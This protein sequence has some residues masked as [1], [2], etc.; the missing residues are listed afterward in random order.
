MPSR[1]ALLASAVLPFATPAFAQSWPARPFRFV[2]PF[3][4]GASLDVLARLIAA[5]FPEVTGQNAVTENRVGGG[6]IIG[7]DS[8]AKLPGDGYTVL[9]VA[10]SF[11]INATL[12][13]NPPFDARRD[14]RGIDSLIVSPHVLIASP[15]LNA[16][17]IPELIAAAR[18]RNGLTYASTGVGTSLHLGGES[19]K[20]ATGMDMTHVVYRGT[21]QA[22]I[23]LYSGRVDVMLTNVADAAPSIRDGRVKAIAVANSARHALLPD[24]PT[25]E[26]LGVRGVVSNSWYG[27]VARSDVPTP[28]ADR[29]HDAIARIMAEPDTL[30]RLNE[31]GLSPMRMARP[32]FDAF[33]AEEF[34]RNGRMI[35]ENGITID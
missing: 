6:T 5:R 30:A 13:P 16:S 24:V 3:G 15:A 32:E 2:V 21:S 25:F 31:M 14:F 23:D 29:L 34:Q 11:T 28:I 22:I 19:L 26:E 18:A 4:A 1:R 7:T 27:V 35:R 17:T 20:K 33:L 8:V 12:I 10:N 9:F